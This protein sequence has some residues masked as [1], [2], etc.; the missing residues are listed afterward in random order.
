M[1]TVTKNTLARNGLIFLRDVLRTNLTDTQSPARSG[2]NWIFKN[3]PDKEEVDFP[4]VILTTGNITRD[5]LVF[6]RSKSNISSMEVTA[7]VW[8]NN[9]ADRDSLAD[10]VVST[11]ITTTS[12]DGTD[13][14]KA[15][16]LW[17]QSSEMSDADTFVGDSPD[18]VYVK[19]V[20]INMGYSGA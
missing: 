12:T 1:T 4:H 17:Y 3:Q 9:I 20:K 5:N 15:K 10:E 13:S 18:I 11:L 2:S 6:N 14:L 16:S 7:T 19:N 8:A